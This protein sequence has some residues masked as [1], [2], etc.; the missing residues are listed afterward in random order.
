MTA[1]PPDVIAV[2]TSIAVPLLSGNHA[3][4]DATFRWAQSR[5]LVLAGHASAETYSV[6][7]RLPEDDRLAADDAVRAMTRRFVGTL[8]VPGAITRRVP[9]I[10]AEAGIVGGA[11]YDGL[12]A[13][14]A[15]HHDRPLATRDARARPTYDALGVRV[16]TVA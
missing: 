14:A 6:L 2:D 8:T 7:T 15:I 10:L 5:R 16:I 12:V 4:H 1:L 9:Q 13:L 11:V 3:Q